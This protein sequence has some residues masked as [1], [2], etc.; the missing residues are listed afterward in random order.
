MYFLIGN[1]DLVEKYNTIWDNVG[2]DIKIQ[3]DSEIKS[4]GDEVTDFYDKCR[5]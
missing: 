2:A 3:F 4:Y 5:L 1:D